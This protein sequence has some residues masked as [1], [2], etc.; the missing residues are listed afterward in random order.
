VAISEE[1]K[2]TPDSTE[3]AVLT[4]SLTG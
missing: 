4:A 2:L 3:A 1:F